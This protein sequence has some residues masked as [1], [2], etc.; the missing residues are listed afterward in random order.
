M[1]NDIPPNS[2]ANDVMPVAGNVPQ[3]PMDTSYV[4]PRDQRS[5]RTYIDAIESSKMTPQILLLL[6]KS[7]LKRC[8]MWALPVGLVLGS[9]VAAVCYFCFPI[10]YQA[11][12][13]L[14]VRSV[15]PYFIF[16]EKQTQR[17]E[18]YLNTQIALIRNPLILDKALEDPKLAQMECLANEK[19]KTAWLTRNLRINANPKNEHVAVSF[20]TKNPNDAANIVNTV[21][22]AYIDFVGDQA[23]QWSRKL[24]SQLNAEIRKYRDV[25]RMYQMD[26]LKNM[27]GT[28]GKGVASNASGGGYAGIAGDSLVRDI[29]L[30][31]AQLAAYQARLATIRDFAASDNIN[32]S[33]LILEEVVS[34][35]TQLQRLEFLRLEAQQYMDSRALKSSSDDPVVEIYREKLQTLDERI[36]TKRNSL[37]PQKEQELRRLKKVQQEQEIS[38]Q[39][40]LVKTQEILVKILKDKQKEQV[41]AEVDTT[42]KIVESEFLRQQLDQTNQILS[43]LET[44]LNNLMTEQSAPLQVEKLRDASV[45]KN[46]NN[47]Q[48]ILLTLFGGSGCFVIPFFIGIV[49]ERMRPRLYH[50]SQIRTAIPQVIIGE[51]ME[52]PVSWVH[53]S[54]FRKRYA[55]YRESVNNWCTHLLLSDPFNRC[56]TLAF[57]SVAGDDGKTFLAVQVAVTMAQMKNAPVLIIDGDMR[58]GYLHTLFGN[59]EVGAGLADVLSYRI[60]AKVPLTRADE[61]APNLE[62]LSA[63]QLFGT[64]PYELLGDGRFRELIELYLNDYSMVLVVLPPVAHAAESLIMAQST[65]SVLLCVRQGETVLAA[66]EDVYRK[67]VNTGS[68]VDGIVVKDIPYSQMAGKD[69]GF[70]DQ[71]EQVRLAH[72][73]QYEENDVHQMQSQMQNQ[74]QTHLGQI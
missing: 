58:V 35:D 47:R 17:Y 57:A 55:R 45:P 12:A 40:A 30:A 27:K 65:D 29:A 67:L 48:Q 19:D 18:S 68:S 61:I 70:A 36:A 21:V 34:K 54:M 39:E 2:Y 1:S 41:S 53:G 62:M 32:I 72:L 51:I 50:V 13:F 7:G 4:S 31:E 46:P 16:D 63:G 74:M 22:N 10:T 3:Y 49:V 66:M 56:R 42:Q 6:V 15:R 73:L 60:G 33:P 71:V 25:A 9:V 59:E 69:G 28:N 5:P 37:W 38:E 8:W 14:H 43:L 20:S 52:P 24:T 11:E 44:R 64:S 26:I 23:N